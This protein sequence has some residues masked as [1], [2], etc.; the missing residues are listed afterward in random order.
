MVPFW[1]LTDFDNRRV[2]WGFAAVRIVT[3]IFFTYNMGHP[4]E[5]WQAI[6]PSYNI[7]YGGVELPWEWDSFYRLR[8]TMYPYFL[9]LPL[10]LL[11]ITGLDSYET[12]RACPLIAHALL[13]IACDRYLWSIGKETVGKNSARIAMLL[14]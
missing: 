6:E 2:R 5:Y 14:Y 12:V 4:D 3:A 11:K 7:V 1:G 8:S 9:S 13:V 10:Y